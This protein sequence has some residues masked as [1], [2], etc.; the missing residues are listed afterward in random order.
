MKRYIFT[1]KVKAVLDIAKYE[2]EQGE[3]RSIGTAHLLLA[4]LQEEGGIAHQILE[5]SNLDY[6][7]VKS[8]ISTILG[9]IEDDK[10]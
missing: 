10:L 6:Q 4:L 3:F 7:T 1:E 5:G 2:A 8:K 9:R